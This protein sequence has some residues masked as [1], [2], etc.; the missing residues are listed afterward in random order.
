MLMSSRHSIYGP[1]NATAFMV[2]SYFA[3]YPDIDRLSA[4]PMLVFLVGSFLVLG[5][6]FRVADLAQYISRTVVV[7]YLT[8]AA[9]Q[10]CVHQTPVVLGLGFASGQ[11]EPHA[12]SIFSEFVHIVTHLET[13]HW[14]TVLVSAATLVAYLG[15]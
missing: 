2:A 15:F 3:A 13:A 10:M 5:A 4:M 12:G 9:V 11:R 7:A 8:G 14:L 1:T 6:Y